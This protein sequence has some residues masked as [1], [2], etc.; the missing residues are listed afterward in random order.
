MCFCHLKSPMIAQKFSPCKDKQKNISYSTENIFLVFAFVDCISNR[1][2]HASVRVK[3]TYSP[4]LVKLFCDDAVIKYRARF[5][6]VANVNERIIYSYIA[7][8]RIYRKENSAWQPRMSDICTLLKISTFDEYLYVGLSKRA[9]TYTIPL[10]PIEI[11]R[12]A[13]TTDNWNT[14]V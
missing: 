5:Q 4:N 10:A 11:Y 1:E 13:L 2:E 8:Y 14:S 7:S 9:V 6:R 3:Y 12:G